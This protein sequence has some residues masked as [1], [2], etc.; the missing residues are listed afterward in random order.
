MGPA[1]RRPGGVCVLAWAVLAW[2]VLACL[3]GDAEAG[4]GHAWRQ[5]VFQGG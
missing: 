2:A 5:A 1:G 3:Q 4:R